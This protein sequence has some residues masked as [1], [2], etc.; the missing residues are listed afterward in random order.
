MANLNFQQAPRSL[1]SGG[2]GGVSVGGR[3]AS[4]LVGGVSGHVTPTFGGALSP[5][6]NSTAIPGGAPSAMASRSTLFGQ[7][8]FADRR[9]PIPTPLSQANS[10]SMVRIMSCHLLRLFYIMTHSLT[11]DK[12]LNRLFVLLIKVHLFNIKKK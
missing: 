10:N 8:A 6:R 12:V 3:V 2:V 4:G 7:R 9:V 5:G 11:L 1:A